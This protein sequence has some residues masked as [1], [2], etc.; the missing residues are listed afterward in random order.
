M[1]I[2]IVIY[3]VVAV[4]LVFWLRSILGTK[5]G[6]ERSRANP[7]A[8]EQE[9]PMETGAQQNALNVSYSVIEETPEQDIRAL[10]EMP[11]NGMAII[12]DQARDGLIDMVRYEK[13][14]D[15]EDFLDKAKD[16]F[17]I[18]V[19][20]FSKGEKE[21]LSQ[22]LG[23]DLYALFEKTIDARDENEKIF[24]EVQAIESVS[25]LEA[26][27][28][29]KVAFITLKFEAKEATTVRNAK[30]EIISGGSDRL[31]SMRDVWVFSRVLKSSDPRWFVVET[32][33][34]FE[35]DNEL[36]PNS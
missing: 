27:L 32:K 2:D 18:V 31:R 5:H 22:L 29:K 3:A 17:A 15:V 25:V 16:V 20:A 28:E 21:T 10:A 6:D 7:F 12:G 1:P 33:G 24:T 13:S 19:E 35:G 11:K 34:D 36:I 26:R 4:G 8:S 23:G 9:Q 30:D 14:L